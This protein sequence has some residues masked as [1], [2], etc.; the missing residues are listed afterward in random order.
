MLL[1]TLTLYGGTGRPVPYEYVWN[2]HPLNLPLEGTPQGGLSCRFAA[3]HLQG[4]RE[5]VDEVNAEH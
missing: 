3:I 4:D 5:A 1:P 2:N